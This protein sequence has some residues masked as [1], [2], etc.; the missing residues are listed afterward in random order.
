MRQKNKEG[1]SIRTETM[2]GDR[3]RLRP[4]ALHH[5]CPQWSD[6]FFEELIMVY[7]WSLRGHELNALQSA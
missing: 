2:E 5:T 6:A 3:V 4:L 7:D 1:K